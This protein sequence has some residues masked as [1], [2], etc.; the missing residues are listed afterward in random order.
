MVLMI[1]L[2]VRLEMILSYILIFN[3][4]VC[5]I[6]KTTKAPLEWVD[7]G[8]NLAKLFYFPGLRTKLHFPDASSGG[9]VFGSHQWQVDRSDV[10]LLV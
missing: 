7:G 4:S 2:K 9:Y 5:F 6:Y 8:E 10:S 3:S 1:F